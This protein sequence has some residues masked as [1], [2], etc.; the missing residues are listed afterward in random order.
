MSITAQLQRLEPGSMVELFE[1][2][3]ENIGAGKYLFHSDPYNGTITFQTKVYSPWS[4]SATGFEMKGKG[5][6]SAP[7]LMMGNL[8]GFITALCLT[9]RDMV[10][11]IVY[12]RQTLVDNLD[13]MP[14]ASPYDELPVQEWRIGRKLGEDNERVQFELA[15][16]I[17]YRNQQLPGRQI[18]ANMCGWRYRSA[19]CGYNGPPVADKNDD[20]TS[21]PQKDVCSLFTTGCKLRYGEYGELPIG[22]F[23]SAGIRR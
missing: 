7:K 15:N 20:P 23:P 18:I 9:F 2:D 6:P 22:S 8:D 19:D 17:D 12:R 10:G 1:I 16:A 14:D 11:A 13:G 5:A 21:D 4:V 3:A